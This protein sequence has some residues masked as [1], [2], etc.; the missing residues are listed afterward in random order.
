MPS[1]AHHRVQ[2][3][4]QRALEWIAAKPSVHLHVPDG[5]LDGAAPFNHGLE[6]S[7][8]ASLLA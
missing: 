3:I 1:S 4:A 2:R 5:R 7:G 6:R 8:D